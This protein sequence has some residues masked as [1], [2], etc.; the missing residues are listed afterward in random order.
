MFAIWCHNSKRV[1]SKILLVLCAFILVCTFCQKH[2][3]LKVNCPKEVWSIEDGQLI[4]SDVQQGTL[5]GVTLNVCGDLDSLLHQ[6][7]AKVVFSD[8]F[9]YYCFSPY[10]EGGVYLEGR[11]VNLQI[12]KDCTKVGSPLIVGSY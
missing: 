12:S 6:F 7:K 2:S 5:V 1:V 8:Q 3:L 9:G 11:Y 10:I 4:C